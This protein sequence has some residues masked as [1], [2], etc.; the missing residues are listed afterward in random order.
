M[1]PNLFVSVLVVGAPC[2]AAFAQPTPDTPPPPPAVATPVEVQPSGPVAESIWPGIVRWYPSAAAKAAAPLS[3]IVQIPSHRYGPAPDGHRVKPVYGEA[4]GRITAHIDIVPGTSLYGCGGVG[5][6]LPLNGRTFVTN[7]GFMP[8]VVALRPDGTAFGVMADTTWRVEVD[9]TDGITMRADGPALPIIVVDA[10]APLAPTTA[11]SQIA[12]W[13]EIP[14]RWVFGP[15]VAA[16]LDADPPE[17]L[18]AALAWRDR[19]F[20]IDSALTG[21]VYLDELSAGPDNAYW[22]SLREMSEALRAR[23]VRSGLA[24]LSAAG[25]GQFHDD[26]AAAGHWLLTG[27]GAPWLGAI[28]GGTG[29]APDVSRD[30]TRAWLGDLM[31]GPMA[32][33]DWWLLA[34]LGADAPDNAGLSPDADLGGAA[35]FAKFRSIY[36]SLLA[37]TAKDAMKA[38]HPDQR[39]FVETG[40]PSLVSQR[41]AHYFVGAPGGTP[42]VGAAIPTILNAS[43]SGQV[44]IG[45]EVPGIPRQEDGAVLARN[46]AIASLMPLM[47]IGPTVGEGSTIEPWAFSPEVEK[48]CREALERR[49]RLIPY[50]YTAALDAYRYGLP[51][52]RPV[53]SADPINPKL[54]DVSDAFILGND[55][56]VRLTWPLAEPAPETA[57]PGWRKFS[58]G[59]TSA[60]LP[61]LSLRPG[62][63]L[64][65]GPV[66]QHDGEKPL[67][68]LTLIVN[69]A[70]DGTAFGTLFEDDGDGYLYQQNQC[71]MAYYTAETV[72]GELK[73]K[74]MRLD[75]A[76]GMAKRKLLVRILLPDGT[77]AAADWW[78]GL[79]LKIKLP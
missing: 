17:V 3:L 40:A 39:P 63:I 52:V 56:L 78:D 51:M 6:P 2:S 62:A 30:A 23:G 28:P 70:A 15:Q 42:D 75:G 11:V 5:G 58:F 9:L 71:R 32:P 20:I 50:L 34:G 21:V 24:V 36:G 79:E 61:E 45:V 33:F 54:R 55:V 73:L 72:D 4:D 41:Q 46:L 18:A 48:T 12:G 59:E 10:E 19:G 67:D 69:P 68:P 31:R 74:M 77:E 27:D 49:S 66:N 64:P 57:L 7:T 22:K 14:P 25:V 60:M 38:A 35:P 76:M 26:G 1:N 37:R 43:L 29:S 44:L 13:Q 47:R 53:F 65:V 16:R 8:W